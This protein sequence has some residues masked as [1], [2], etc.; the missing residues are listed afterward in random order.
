M[1]KVWLLGALFA[2]GC[3]SDIEYVD[4][5]DASATG[6]IGGTQSLDAA[7][8][9][10]TGGTS[11]VDSGAD[12]LADVTQPDGSAACA[13]V[14]HF[15]IDA[16]DDSIITPQAPGCNDEQASINHGA[17]PTLLVGLD[18]CPNSSEGLVKFPVE[19]ESLRSAFSAGKVLDVA[20]V[21]SSDLAYKTNFVPGSLN[22]FAMTSDWDEGEGSYDGAQWYFATA[23]CTCSPHTNACCD[24]KN[25]WALPGAAGT[26]DRN[27]TPAA[28]IN[29][30][31][32]DVLSVPLNPIHLASRV[33]T[34][35]SLLLQT[36]DNLKLFFVSIEGSN[37]KSVS[38]PRLQGTYC[39]D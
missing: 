12:A 32:A 7:S 37:A 2:L 24:Y 29:V 26:M 21:L 23:G 17:D 33:T 9:W 35:L 16:E 1:G 8:E 27:S 25:K 19:D 10:G 6:G 22:V 18:D 20:L 13:N 34:K 5:T 4:D 15:N 39:N 14:L 36:D 11:P 31:A 38:P 30:S 3:S 28:S